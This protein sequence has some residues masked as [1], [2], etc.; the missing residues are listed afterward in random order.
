VKLHHPDPWLLFLASFSKE[1][2]RTMKGIY[3][4]L[5]LF[6]FYR[7][8]CLLLFLLVSC[9]A[10][11]KFDEVYTVVTPAVL[12]PGA[13]IPAPQGASILTITGKIGATNKA[14]GIAMDRATIEQAGVVE[15]TVTDPF[16]E[17]PVRY[18]GVLMRDLLALW[19]VADDAQHVQI[20]AL[21]DYMIEIPIADFRHYPVL[22]ALQADEVYMQPDY[23]GPA[24]LVYP[25]DHYEFDILA[26]QRKWIW[27]IK[28]INIQ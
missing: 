5:K 22:F 27:Q 9:D 17:R 6:S 25:V 1:E 10:S 11:A 26:V 15:Y 14:A 24:M 23:R 13:A 18:R 21:N 2:T 20:T 12:K 16:E 8:T 4:W 28:T 3:R 19:Q 7:S